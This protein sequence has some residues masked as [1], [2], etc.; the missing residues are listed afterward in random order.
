M[1]EKPNETLE[2]KNARLLEENANLQQ[3]VAD[4]EH[5][6]TVMRSQEQQMAAYHR[7][8]TPAPGATHAIE[9]IRHQ[10][11]DQILEEGDVQT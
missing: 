11:S 6:L 7:G 3:R 1:S 10:Q 9:K 5:D 2:E 4:L 8:S